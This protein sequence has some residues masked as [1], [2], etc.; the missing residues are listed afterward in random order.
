[1]LDF[2]GNGYT[3]RGDNSVKNV[4]TSFSRGFYFKRKI[5]INFPE[6]EPFI[7]RVQCV[8]GTKSIRT[9]VNSLPLWPTRIHLSV[10][11]YSSGG[12]LVFILVSSFSSFWSI[13]SQTKFDEFRRNQKKKKKKKKKNSV[14]RTRM[15]TLE[16]FKSKL[17]T[18]D[19]DGDGQG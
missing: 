10:S 2:K 12:Q 1:M 15:L 3:I 11:S 18:P 16:K 13:R 14:Q 5:E 7:E 8:G 4:W 19:A 17:L 6:V 9:Y